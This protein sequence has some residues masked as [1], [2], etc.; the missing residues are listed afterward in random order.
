LKAK[1]PLEERFPM[2]FKSET[3]GAPAS[4]GNPNNYPETFYTKKIKKSPKKS[5]T[6]NYPQTSS[7]KKL[8]EGGII[9]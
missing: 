9:G 7:T 4:Y 2:H 1:F 3:R 8:P 6:L 5:S